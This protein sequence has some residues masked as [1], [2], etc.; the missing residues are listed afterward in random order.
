MIDGSVAGT[1][2]L[3]SHRRS[4]AWMLVV[5]VTDVVMLLVNWCLLLH[6]EH[7]V[8]LHLMLSV[9]APVL[10]SACAFLVLLVLNLAGGLFL[11]DVGL[12]GLVQMTV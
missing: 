1:L 11:V 6:L 8:G 10:A 3:V 7:C 12:E 9:E 2:F 5:V 4:A